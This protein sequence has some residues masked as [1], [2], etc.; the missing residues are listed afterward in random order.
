MKQQ[1]SGPVA[2]LAVLLTLV[3]AA[4]IF[5]NPKLAPGSVG[6]HSHGSETEQLPYEPEVNERELSALRQGLQPFGIAVVYPPLAEDRRQGARVAFVAPSSPAGKAGVKAG[7]LVVSFGGKPVAYPQA[8]IGALREVKPE[9]KY[10]LEVVRASK[11]QK[12]AIT[13]IVPLPPEE[14]PS[15]R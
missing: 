10:E 7:D 5:H 11:T 4:I 15:R 12:L 14:M 9:G 6:L 2:L 1:V 3:V 13:G 8:L